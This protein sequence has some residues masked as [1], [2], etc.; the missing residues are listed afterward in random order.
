MTGTSGITLRKNGTFTVTPMARP[1]AHEPRAAQLV[2]AQRQRQQSPGTNQASHHSGS[3]LTTN[4]RPNA[5][6]KRG[7]QVNQRVLVHGRRV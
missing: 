2:R 7:D 4:R 6:G 5:Q 3:R 1:A